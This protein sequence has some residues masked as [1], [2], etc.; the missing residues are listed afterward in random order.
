MTG[1]G[2]GLAFLVCAALGWEAC[3]V[4]A[5]GIVARLA[6]TPRWRSVL[7]PAIGIGAAAVFGAWRG[8]PPRVVVPAAWVD[9]AERLGGQ[10]GEIPAATG[11]SQRF[12]LE[13]TAFSADG[14]QWTSLYEPATVCVT[15]PR[16]PEVD[17]GDTVRLSGRLHSILDEPAALRAFLRSRGC[18]ASVFPYSLEIQQRGM[19]IRHLASRIGRRLTASAVGA[20]PGDPGALLAG[21]VTGDDAALSKQ[22]NDNFVQTSTTHL[23]AVSG[24]NIAF[25]VGV[26]TTLGSATL[27]H[28]RI[29]WQFLVVGLIWS[30]ALLTGVDP[31]VVRAALV[32]TAALFAIRVGRRP[33]F[34]T[35]MILSAALIVAMEPQQM[36]RLAFQLSVV[37]SLALSLVLGQVEPRTWQAWAWAALLAVL[38]AQIATLPVLLTIDMET[39]LAAVPANVLVGPLVQLAFPLAMI[40]SVVDVVLPPLA[41]V[42]FFPAELCALAVL[43]IV[44]LA[45]TSPEVPLDRLGQS[46]NWLIALAA[47]IVIAGLSEE[48]RAWARRLPGAA[49]GMPWRGWVVWGAAL[50]GCAAMLALYAGR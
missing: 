25:L 18:T 17:Q 44:D 5:A 36:W 37:A 34:V 30:Y 27:W 8:E 10:V 12:I 2:L 28:R 46:L 41:E 45:A 16:Y 49:V 48:V 22:R 50:V 47:A 14:K 39:R 15:A 19:G 6:A 3:A 40:A 4:V 42:L 24:A 11:R 7:V 21:L 26:G 20:A 31:P 35:L 13:V 38:T 32:A 23:T 1:I 43:W 29:V 33:D 9:Q